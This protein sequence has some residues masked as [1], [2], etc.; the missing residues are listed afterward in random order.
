MMKI[1]RNDLCSCGSGKKFKNC[2]ERNT[3]ISSLANTIDMNALFM[4]AVQL[5]Q[6]NDLIQAKQIYQKILKVNPQHADSTHYL[7][8]IAHQQQKYPLAIKIFK[9]A[10]ELNPIMGGYYT[11]LGNAYKKNG[12]FSEAIEVYLQAVKIEPSL[13]AAHFNLGLLLIDENQQQ[14]LKSLSMAVQLSPSNPVFLLGLGNALYQAEDIDQAHD[15]FEQA[16]SLNPSSVEAHLCLSKT[17]QRFSKV[18][19]ALQHFQQAEKLSPDT[20]SILCNI[21]FILNYFETDAQLIFN[22]TQ[23]RMHGFESRITPIKHQPRKNSSKRRLKI[24]YISYDLRQH[25]MRFFIEPILRNHDRSRFEVFCYHTFPGMDQSSNHLKALSEHWINSATLSDEELSQ[26]IYHD[27]I[28]ILIDL[29]GLSSGTRLGVLARKPAPIQITML[30]YLN[31][32]GLTRIDY[33]IADVNTSPH[34]LYENLSTE[35]LLRLPHCQWCYQPDDNSP[36]V[37]PLPAKQRGYITF[38]AIHNLAK[39]TSEMVEIWSQILKRVD[40]SK[41]MMIIWGEKAKTHIKELFARNNISEQQLII[42]D[43]VPYSEYLQIYHQFDIALDSY[44]YSGGTTSC[45]SLWMGVP[46]IS[47]PGTSPMSRGGSS[48]LSTLKLTQLI[49]KDTNNYIDIA[50]NLARDVNYLEQ[51]RTELRNNMM[52]SPLMDALAYT[53]ALEN[54]YVKTTDCEIFN[55]E[56]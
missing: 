43:P 36:E 23:K 48:I 45:E 54:L 13:A 37:N 53:S 8:L 51:L 52:Q 42:V 21:P 9:K 50:S 17:L 29:S 39:V 22:E 27:K 47:L 7:A 11:N 49:A 6:A 16:L 40:Q 19:V 34:G 18:R 4:Q 24:A 35:K 41:L 3:R 1:K 15:C 30:G 31:S 25:A 26:R 33:R 32:T 10:I 2:C 55:S 5:H 20:E 38:G 44:P 56:H 28:D 14:G 46:Y 12:Q